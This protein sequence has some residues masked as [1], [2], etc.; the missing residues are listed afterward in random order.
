MEGK[1]KMFIKIATWYLNRHITR[2]PSGIG[3]ID[4]NTD[5]VIWPANG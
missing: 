5:K 1:T 2:M 4:P 3:I